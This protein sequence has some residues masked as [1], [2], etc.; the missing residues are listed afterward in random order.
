[1]EKQR[2]QISINGY[3]QNVEKLHLQERVWLRFYEIQEAL[4][5]ELQ[6][7]IN[8]ISLLLHFLEISGQVYEQAANVAL[9]KETTVMAFDKLVDFKELQSLVLDIEQSEQT[10]KTR[11]EQIQQA[12][13]QQDDQL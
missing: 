7:Y 12:N 10:I 8:K 11:L 9:L 13:F 3:T 4:T 2:I 5:A 6:E 1:M